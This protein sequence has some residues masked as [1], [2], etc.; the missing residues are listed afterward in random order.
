ML[1]KQRNCWADKRRLLRKC[2]EASPNLY[3]E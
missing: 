2:G 1:H 3:G